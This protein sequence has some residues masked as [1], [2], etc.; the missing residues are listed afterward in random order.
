MN[1]TATSGTA[2]ARQGALHPLSEAGPVGQA[3]E[4]VVVGLVGE[5]VLELL[6]FGDVPG[7]EHQ[8]VDV[9]VL[10]QV[11]RDRLAVQPGAVAVEDP[12]GGR[13]RH[14]WP[15]GRLADE[16]GDALLVVGVDQHQQVGGGQLG[17]LV[18]EHARDRLAL[19]ADE[20]FGVEDGD[21]VGGVLHQRPE[22]L[23]AGPQG[24]LRRLALL[25]LGGQ[26]PPGAVEVRAH[27]LAQRQDER[28]RHQQHHP[29]EADQQP[30]GAAP[31]VER[32]AERPEEPLLLLVVELL[33]VEVQPAQGGAHPG[34]LGAVGRPRGGRLGPGDATVDRTE[35]L[36]DRLQRRGDQGIVVAE[37]LE[38]EQL[39]AEQG[40]ADLHPLQVAAGR[41]LL[42]LDV[43]Q[44]HL[45]LDV[46]EVAGQEGHLAEDGG[47]AG[48]VDVGP[49]DQQLDHDDQRDQ[50]AD[51]GQLQRAPSAAQDTSGIGRRASR[52]PH[53][54]QTVQD[55]H[56]VS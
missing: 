51:E 8:A 49:Q 53:S 42:H 21:D 41:Q 1:S 9:G 43:E 56:P 34:H 19:V 44:Q 28:H 38:Q 36:V 18:A 16:A 27:P 7:V 22:P 5:L 29:A 4:P 35:V 23:L 50:H 14:P 2:A 47:G 37:A 26:R 55:R 13:R 17:R 45:A 40:P 39:V 52:R 15:P 46:D 32:S 3:G 30:L 54:A 33:D 10:Q 48:H 11:P 20:P 31:C 6:A 24:R 12:P 25:D